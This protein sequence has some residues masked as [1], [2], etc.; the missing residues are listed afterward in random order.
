[1]VRDPTHIVM[2][3]AM[4]RR[5]SQ[6]LRPDSSN[7]PAVAGGLL[8]SHIDEF[9]RRATRYNNLPFIVLDD[10]TALYTALPF[11]EGGGSA[12]SIY[13]VSLRADGLC[14]IQNGEPMVDDLGELQ[15]APKFRTRIEWYAGITAMHP[16]CAARVFGI[17]NAALTA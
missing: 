1:K 16:F 7:N 13:V 11:T 14:G 6:A 2:N 4:A 10:N 8:D 5:F 15:T 17:T 12:T 3:Q 9:G